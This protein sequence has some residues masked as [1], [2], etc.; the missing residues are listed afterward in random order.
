MNGWERHVDS[1][2]RSALM[3]PPRLHLPRI[4]IA[5]VV[6]QRCQVRVE[7]VGPIIAMGRLVGLK[8]VPFLPVVAKVS[9]LLR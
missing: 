1:D 7:P 4:P 2:A 5:A 8:R 9:F 3:F 6:Q